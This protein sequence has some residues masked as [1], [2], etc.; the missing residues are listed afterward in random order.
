MKM[1][2]ILTLMLLAIV[3]GTMAQK[4]LVILHTNDTHSTIFPLNVNLADTMKAGRGGFM[5][6]VAMLEQ[7]R[8]AEPELLL[9]D[10][11]DFSQGSAYYTMFKGDT[12]IELMNLMHYDAVTIGNHEF[13]FGLENMARIFKK[14][15]F[16]I[17][18]AN[19]D[20]TGTVVEGLVKPYVIVKRKG[21][22]IGVFGI[23]PKMDGLVDKTK[24]QGVKFLDP[25][26]EAQKIVNTLRKQKCDLIICLSHLGWQVRG[27]DDEQLIKNT[28]GIDLVLGGHSH[29]FFE[30][31]EY[32]KNKDGKDVPVDQNGKHAIFVGK[33]VLDMVKK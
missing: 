6:R 31:L 30:K 24:C 12:E 15:N 25:A 23:S 11:G 19:Y 32:A 7:E 22:R 14:A 16:P 26:T 3:T 5:R 2:Y 18:C 28:K 21:L 4:Q 27:I 33:M 20:F 9:F 10:S 17:V 1:K 13:D 8:K 29:S